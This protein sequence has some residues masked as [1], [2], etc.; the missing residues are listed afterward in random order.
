MG[1]PWASVHA[2]ERCEVVSI[3]LKAR[4]KGRS[5]NLRGDCGA[6]EV[7]VVGSR[8]YWASVAEMEAG[9]S[10]ISMHVVKL[11]S[12]SCRLAQNC[13]GEATKNI[14]EKG[15]EMT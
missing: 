3:L 6:R 12:G 10:D 8:E 11:S 5:G 14:N 15:N 13:C 4:G 9:R 2:R 1:K 7:E